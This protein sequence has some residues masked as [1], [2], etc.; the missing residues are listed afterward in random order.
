MCCLCGLTLSVKAQLSVGEDINLDFSK[1]MESIDKIN[2]VSKPMQKHLAKSL[3]SMRT[4]ISD[5]K[6][7]PNPLTKAKFEVAFSNH[8]KTLVED[9]DD[10]LDN[11]QE[12]QWALDDI[13][14]KVKTVT[15]RL[16]YNNDKMDEKIS[17]AKEKLDNEYKALKEVAREVRRAGKKASPDLLRKFKSMDRHYRTSMRNAAMHKRIKTMLHRTLVALSKNGLTFAQ[18]TKDMNDWFASLKDQRDSF[19]KLAEARNDIQKL[20][21]LMTQGSSSSVMQTFKKLGSIN[22][23]MTGFMDTFDAME[24]DLDTLNSFDAGYVDPNASSDINTDAGLNHRLNELLE[25]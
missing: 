16:K 11:R 22:K 12:I 17:R 9:M 14:T 10:I 7:N 13:S 1:E 2:D 4:L 21:Q 3:N 24:N 19:L 15:K 25:N 5:V 6:A 8:I 23:Q 18:S 20:S